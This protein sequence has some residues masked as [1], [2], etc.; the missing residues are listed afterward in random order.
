MVGTKGLP[1]TFGGV[2]RHVEEIGAGLA[3]RGHEVIVHCRQSYV[4]AGPV[5]VNNGNGDGSDGSGG[6]GGSSKSRTLTRYRGMRIKMGGSLATKHLDALTHSAAATWDAT[7]S[8]ADIVHFHALGPSVFSLLP[9]VRRGTASI[10]SVH[11]LDWQRDKWSWPASQM[12][13]LGEWTSGVFPNRTICVSRSLADHYKT[14]FPGQ[15]VAYVPNGVPT[16][17]ARPAHLIEEAFGLEQDKYLLFVGRFVPEKAPHLLLEAFSKVPTEFRLVVAGG[18]Q[19]ADDYELSLREL[20]RADE[21]VIFTGYVGGELLDELYSNARLFVLPSRLEGL[22]IT[23]L[24]ALSYGTPVLA[25]DIDCH[26]EILGRDHEYGR[27]FRTGDRSSLSGAIAAGITD[28]RSKIK[29]GAGQE[30]VQ[31]DF[32]WPDVIDRIEDIYYQVSTR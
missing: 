22:P 8:G 2:E 21:R 30:M 28:P 23:L 32:R 14:K 3:E 7:V 17:H 5:V 26:I 24:E 12:L 6:S 13:R 10:V 11:G 4:D 15:P 31:K 20:A 27:L 29:A 9:R 16:A 19:F 1:A 18:S 25:S